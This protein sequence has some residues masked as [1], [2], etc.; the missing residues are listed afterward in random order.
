MVA[1]IFAHCL[2]EQ[3]LTGHAALTSECLG[4]RTQNGGKHEGSF[5][6]DTLPEVWFRHKTGPKNHGRNAC[7]PA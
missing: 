5:H 4:S 2:S 7:T 6:A 1:Q 3:F